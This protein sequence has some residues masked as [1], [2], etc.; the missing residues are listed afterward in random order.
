MVA[1]PSAIPAP[2]A[3]LA[4]ELGSLLIAHTQIRAPRWRLSAI[5]RRVPALVRFGVSLDS[6]R[7]QIRTLATKALCPA[8]LREVLV[9]QLVETFEVGIVHALWTPDWRGC[10]RLAVDALVRAGG[11]QSPERA[12]ERIVEITAAGPRGRYCT[13]RVVQEKTLADVIALVDRGLGEEAERVARGLRAHDQPYAQAHLGRLALRVAPVRERSIRAGAQLLVV[14][15]A[16]AREQLDLA[17]SIAG[18]IERTLIR[19]YA[20][21][22]LARALCLR[23]RIVDALRLLHAV[24]RAELIAERDL[25]RAEIRLMVRRD[26]E[27]YHGVDRIPVWALPA[28]LRPRGWIGGDKRRTR[29]I[30]AQLLRGWL[31]D[32]DTSI[33][34]A[35]FY[36]GRVEPA[37]LF[38]LLPRVGI[39][40]D[41]ALDALHGSRA[42]DR[43]LAARIGMRADEL[44]HTTRELP[45]PMRLGLAGLA[46]YVQRHRELV[47]LRALSENGVPVRFIDDD[48]TQSVNERTLTNHL[49]WR[50]FSGRSSA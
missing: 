10:A 32:H 34:A 38:E 25:L 14:R 41:E 4:S 31:R 27:T 48:V 42:I 16:I 33:D 29:I 5:V 7:E 49:F 15:E 43:L 3:A 47:R 45:E 18:G 21:I 11:P 12:I 37:S 13:P 17:R 46:T 1:A 24:T 6:S 20:Y 19:Q 28:W 35:S 40:I 26:R 39:D 50:T 36:S 2:D 30:A 9:A 23:D 44:A 22:E 8:P